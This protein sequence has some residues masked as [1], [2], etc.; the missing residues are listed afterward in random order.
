MGKDDVLY[1]SGGDL[2][3]AVVCSTPQNATPLAPL[4]RLWD[5]HDRQQ[6]PRSPGG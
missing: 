3:L 5:G 1:Y 4:G 2:P 6:D